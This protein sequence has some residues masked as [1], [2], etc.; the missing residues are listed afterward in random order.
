MDVFQMAKGIIP[1]SFMPKLQPLGSKMTDI[2]KGV[3]C[4]R[5]WFGRGLSDSK[6]THGPCTG[7]VPRGYRARFDEPQNS[8]LRGGGGECGRGWVGPI[9]ISLTPFERGQKVGSTHEKS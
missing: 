6:K 5:G 4:L 8:P 2:Q 1:E 7:D 9:T 3:A